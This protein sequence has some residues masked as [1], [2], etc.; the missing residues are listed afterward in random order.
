MRMSCYRCSLNAKCCS[1]HSWTTSRCG[2]TNKSTALMKCSNGQT[3]DQ[4]TGQEMCQVPLLYAQS[5]FQPRKRTKQSTCPKVPPKHI[6]GPRFSLFPLGGG[7]VQFCGVGASDM[8]GQG[9]HSHT[10][11]RIHKHAN[12]MSTKLNQMSVVDL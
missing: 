3:I 5:R 4:F 1:I 9:T 11:T 8:S 7:G 10:R 2:T 12:T 6:T